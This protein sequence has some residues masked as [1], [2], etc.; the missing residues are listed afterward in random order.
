MSSGCRTISCLAVFFLLES[1]SFVV[2]L[3]FFFL[4]LFLFF[5]F[6]LFLSCRTSSCLSLA[7]FFILEYL[8]LVVF[9]DWVVFWQ[10]VAV[11]PVT[12][13]SAVSELSQC[14]FSLSWCI[15]RAESVTSGCP[16]SDHE[17]EWGRELRQQK[18]LGLLFV[19]GER[20]PR[21]EG[22]LTG[23]FIAGLGRNVLGSWLAD[24]ASLTRFGQSQEWSRMEIYSM[25]FLSVF[26]CVYLSE[27]LISGWAELVEW[28]IGMVFLSGV[29]VH[30]ENLELDLHLG[31]DGNQV[32][33]GGN[34][35]DRLGRLT[36]PSLTVFLVDIYHSLCDLSLTPLACVLREL[37]QAN[38]SHGDSRD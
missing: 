6:F 11:C 31:G 16:G 34:G 10:S 23:Y 9:Q 12:A 2:F 30:L 33:R 5:L 32:V 3:L 15:V 36:V 37:I 14:W 29:V 13:Y 28:Q 27:W 1:V 8:S 24:W 20:E 22:E 18:G 38:W 4:F 17:E 26:C 19:W 35:P 25:V 7:V 21:Q